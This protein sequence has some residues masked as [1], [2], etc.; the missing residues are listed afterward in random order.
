VTCLE[1]IPGVG[2]TAAAVIIA[3]VLVDMTRF[4]GPAHVSSW[5]RFAPGVKESAGR[6]KGTGSTGHGDRHLARVL[7]E[8]AVGTSRTNTILGERYRRIARRCAK[9]KAVVTVRSFHSGHR[10][11]PAVRRGRPASRPGP[12]Y[13][14][15]RL[16]PER[17]K[18]N[19]IRELEAPG[20]RV[21][22]QP[23]A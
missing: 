6:Q 12:G 8:A 10:L 1:E 2:A 4:P 20:Y 22:L 21:T 18:R 11:V 14:D 17:M 7:G 16:N 13:Y 3:E 15:S 23:A 9:K 5:A 19:H